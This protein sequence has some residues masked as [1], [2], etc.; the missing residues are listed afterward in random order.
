MVWTADIS[1]PETI[2][3]SAQE[4]TDHLLGVIEPL[5]GPT[6]IVARPRFEPLEKS[7][8]AMVGQSGHTPV[9]ADR[10]RD[11]ANWMSEQTEPVNVVSLLALW[12]RDASSDVLAELSELAAIDTRI[13]FAEPTLGL[14]ISS[15]IQRLGRSL[16]SRRLGVSFHRDIPT[17]LRSA[18]WQ[19]TTV[20]RVSVGMPA[21]IMT[22]VVGEARKYAA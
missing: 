18:G 7:V 22:F 21:S 2:G 5:T 4:L 13:V 1:T 6:C 20:K 3:I 16:F 10:I 19:P 15:G 8:Q 12:H 17:I 14:G 9:V 11:V